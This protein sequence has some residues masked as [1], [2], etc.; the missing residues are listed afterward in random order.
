MAWRHLGLLQ[1]AARAPDPVLAWCCGLDVFEELV[2]ALGSRARAAITA[3]GGLAPLVSPLPACDWLPQTVG[4]LSRQSTESLQAHN[5]HLMI[6]ALVCDGFRAS[7]EA[8][9][10]PQKSN[11]P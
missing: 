8:L 9:A 10:T 2:S 5:G 6:N 4:I 3:E 7:F 11:E 1:K